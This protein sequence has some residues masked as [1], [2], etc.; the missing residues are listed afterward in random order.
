MLSLK[1]L[2]KKAILLAS[3]YGCEVFNLYNNL[4]NINRINGFLRK[5]PKRISDYDDPACSYLFSNKH[6]Y[7]KKDKIYLDVL[8]FNYQ[9]S[10]KELFKNQSLEFL[11]YLGNGISTV[12]KIVQTTGLEK[13]AARRYYCFRLRRLCEMIE[14]LP[15]CYVFIEGISKLENLSIYLNEKYKIIPDV[16]LN[17]SIKIESQGIPE[18]CFERYY[19]FIQHCDEKKFLKII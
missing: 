12:E 15:N 4:I 7:P 5:S 19:A 2:Q 17:Y 13:E 1:L 16:K 6:L 11:F 3:H 9:I 8:L 18:N 10:C 14:K